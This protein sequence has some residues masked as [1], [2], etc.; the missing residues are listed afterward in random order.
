MDGF[1]DVGNVGIMPPGLVRNLNKAIVKAVRVS[2]KPVIELRPF[3]AR[4]G[5]ELRERDWN[6]RGNPIL[7]I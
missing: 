2:S 4:E 7:F 3:R 5:T 1:A 6:S